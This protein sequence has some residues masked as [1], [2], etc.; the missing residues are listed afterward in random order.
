MF[1][2]PWAASPTANRPFT[3]VEWPRVLEYLRKAGA[4]WHR[5]VYID[6]RDEDKAG[7]RADSLVKAYG[8]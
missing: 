7:I 5:V 6:E 4:R 2:G 1:D 8:A 3:V